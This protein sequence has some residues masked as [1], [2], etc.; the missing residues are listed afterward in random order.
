MFSF[1]N[2]FAVKDDEQ[3]QKYRI[4]MYMDDIWN[5]LSVLVN[6]DHDEFRQRPTEIA[7]LLFS[8]GMIGLVKCENGYWFGKAGY[9]GKLDK[10]GEGTKAVVSFGD[11]SVFTGTINKD[12]VLLR[13]NTLGSSRLPMVSRYSYM[14]ADCDLSLVYNLLYSRVCPIPIVR[15]DTEQ[16][17][18]TTV[19]ENLIK[20]KMSIFKKDTIDPSMLGLSNGNQENMLNLTNPATSEY[21]Q[22]LNRLHDEIMVRLAL[23][24]GVH[25]SARDKG[26]QLNESELQAFNDLASVKGQILTCELEQFKKD[27]LECFGIEPVAEVRKYI[28]DEQDVTEVEESQESEVDDNVNE[29]HNGDVDTEKREQ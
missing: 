11:G 7:K 1:F 27:C 16:R 4:Q 24:M 14:L 12:V 25:V 3:R 13:A 28:Y 19:I 17:S 8:C 22:H 9:A 20:G 15:T 23:D 5:M 26:A 29:N 2:S 6:I 21:L 10:N 18:L